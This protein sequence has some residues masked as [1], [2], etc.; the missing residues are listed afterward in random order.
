MHFGF[1]IRAWEDPWIPARLPCH[2]VLVVHPVMTLSDFIHGQPKNWDVEILVAL[3][4]IL[5][6]QSLYISQSR[7]DKFCYSYTKSDHWV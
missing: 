2:N 5:L 6:I 4:D 3:E 1:E 7:G